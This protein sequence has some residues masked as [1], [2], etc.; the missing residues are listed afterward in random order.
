MKKNF[1]DF[2]E[3]LNNFHPT[4]KFTHERSREE[5]NFLDVT[6]RVIYA[7]YITNLYPVGERLVGS[8]KCDKN[9]HH[10]CE[11]VIETET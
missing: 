11:N 8:R 5:I 10:V 3:R 4:L 6:F 7:E 1:F 2:S 9:H